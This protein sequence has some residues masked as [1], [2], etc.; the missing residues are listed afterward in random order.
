MKITVQY[1]EEEVHVSL[2]M[3]AVK[4]VILNA[5]QQGLVS[6]PLLTQM[7]FPDKSVAI[8]Y[9]TTRKGF[10]E[11]TVAPLIIQTDFAVGEKG[12]EDETER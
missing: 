9:R 11:F 3:E 10:D 2:A 8:I 1:K 5:Y 12:I 4:A 6:P 7:N